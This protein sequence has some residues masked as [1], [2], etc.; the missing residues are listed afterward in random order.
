MS[1][2]TVI[3]SSKNPAATMQSML[4]KMKPQIEA[5]LPKH[6]NADRV[7]RIAMTVYRS[8]PAFQKCDPM[9][10][11]ASLMTA[12]QLG[13]EV[14]ILGQ[15]YLIPYKDQVTFVPGWQGLVDLVSRAG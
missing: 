9:S 2:V 8:N 6:M 3:S 1:N 10:F 5:A 11:I 7:A 12:T 14:G 4:D 13:L 15:A